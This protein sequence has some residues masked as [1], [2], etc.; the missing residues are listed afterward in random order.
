MRFRRLFAIGLLA[1]VVTACSSDPRDIKLSEM[2]QPEHA[3]RLLEALSPEEREL[4]AR[5]VAAN[6]TLDYKLTVGEAL[7]VAAEER[8]TRERERVEAA[9]A[10][11]AF[12]EEQERLAKAE[13]ETRLAQLLDQKVADLALPARRQAV[14]EL[15][16]L[17]MSGELDPNIR[18]PLLELTLLG[19]YV[20]AGVA[21][22]DQT[23]G[24]AFEQIKKDPAAAQVLLQEAREAAQEKQ[25]NDKYL[26]GLFV[27]LYVERPDVRATV[28]G[29]LP[30]D[31][32]RMLDEYVAAAQREPGSNVLGMRVSQALEAA[33]QWK[34]T[35]L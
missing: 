35:S 8:D 30:I 28:H 20:E 23:L 21:P 32:V 19:Q 24:E 14:A 26:A 4:L 18:P 6:A 31:D 3:T 25:R 1:A 27:K 7:Q 29:I 13:R 17:M 11:G 2:N 10:K 16:H 9:A 34:E 12:L 22:A 33:R 5:Y 15:Q